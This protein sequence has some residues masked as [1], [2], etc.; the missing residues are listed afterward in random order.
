[1]A[2]GKSAPRP[3]KRYPK[4]RKGKKSSGNV[5]D[6]ASLSVKT[7]LSHGT[8]I[9][10]AFPANTM[11]SRLATALDE[12]K[13]AA[14]VAQAFQHFKIQRIS[15]TFKPSFDTYSPQANTASAA[16]S[17]PVLYYMIDKS[18]SVPTNPTLE[19]LKQMGARPK[20]FDEK[21]IVISWTPSVITVD[22]NA[23]G[24][25]QGSG[26][27]ISPWLATADK[28]VHAGVW[29]PN[30]L[31]HLGCY[32]Y[33]DSLQ[34]GASITYQIEME[35]QF[36]FKKPLWTAIPANTH[37]VEALPFVTYDGS[38]DGLADGRDRGVVTLL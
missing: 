37:A 24:I 20:A 5:P 28:T 15:L 17:K 14:L 12:S 8:P 29:S 27:K 19:T 34:G 18:G 26:Y 25:S 23:E 10:T 35:V 31:N 36:R 32:W 30:T 13:R 38:S 4:A 7:T 16:Y 22:Q 1:M 2:K 11:Y 9:T 33:V 21:P 6:Q 3:A